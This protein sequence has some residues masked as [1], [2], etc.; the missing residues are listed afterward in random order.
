MQ[1]VDNSVVG[2]YYICLVKSCVS[3]MELRHNLD[4][5]HVDS[6]NAEQRVCVNITSGSFESFVT[7]LVSTT[8][9]SDIFITKGGDVVVAMSSMQQF[10]WIDLNHEK[11][12]LH[13]QNRAQKHMIGSTLY[14][15]CI[16]LTEH[17]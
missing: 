6:C 16:L 3:R 14:C 8:V 11:F 10:E 4:K 1:T 17:Y 5:I 2:G 9:V 15:T 7:S 13:G 12:D